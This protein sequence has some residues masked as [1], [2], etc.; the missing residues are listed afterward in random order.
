MVLRV[1][2]RLQAYALPAL[3]EHCVVVLE[4]VEA[5]RQK[6]LV[7]FIGHDLKR[8]HAISIPD[9][10]SRGYRIEH[11]VYLECQIRHLRKRC[12]LKAGKRF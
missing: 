5:Q 8:A 4:K 11:S 2:R 6:V 3:V 9:I 10:A 7:S 1:A 12:L